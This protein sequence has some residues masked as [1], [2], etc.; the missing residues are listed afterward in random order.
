MPPKKLERTGT[1]FEDG[2]DLGFHVGNPEL[3][4]VD[5]LEAAA[6]QAYIEETPDARGRVVDGA[7]VVSLA[8]RSSVVPPAEATP[9]TRQA[10]VFWLSSRIVGMRDKA[11]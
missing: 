7:T 9:Q 11:A 1:L 5:E 6:H 8:D 4:T 10:E 3:M 2:A